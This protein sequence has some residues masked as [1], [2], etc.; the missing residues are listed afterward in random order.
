MKNIFFDI[1]TIPSQEEW[2]K[3]DIADSISHHGNISKPETIAGWVKNKKPAEIEKVWRK[4]ALDATKGE[5]LQFGYAVNDGA[6]TSFT[7]P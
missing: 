4:T 2:V 6:L 1:E 5:I 7:A 3:Q